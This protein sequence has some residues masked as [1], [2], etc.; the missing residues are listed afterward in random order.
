MVNNKLQEAL[1]YNMAVVGGIFG[2]YAV[3]DWFDNLGSAAT[4]NLIHFVICL[5]GENWQE[6]VIRLGGIAIY[7]LGITITVVVTRKTKRNIKYLSIII[8]IVA[9]LICGLLPPTTDKI[10]ALYPIFFAMSIQ[11]N[12]FKGV[13]GYASSTIFSTNNLRQTAIGITDYI[14]T[15][16]KLQLRRAR[17]FGTTLL[18]FHIGV[19]V[20]YLFWINH[21]IHCIW[22]AYVPLASGIILT[23]LESKQKKFMQ[24]SV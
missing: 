9:A 4:A 20:C 18:F 5:V 2:G 1:H 6:A 8:S 11:W 7:F 12:S 16:D 17:F 3:L 19:A 14:C 24:N 10:M 13:Y 22:I 21:G 23:A 15:K